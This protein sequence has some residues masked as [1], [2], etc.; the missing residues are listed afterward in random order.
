[1]PLPSPSSTSDLAPSVRVWDPFVRVLH[2]GLVA[3]VATAWWSGDDWKALHLASGYIAAAL[4]TARVVWGFV[5]PRHARF[6]EFV[7]RPVVVVRYL[8]AIARGRQARYLGHNP[9]GGAM[10]AALLATLAAVCFTGWLLT[11]DAFWGTVTMEIVHET[12]TNIALV[13]IAAHVVGVAVASIRHRENLVRSMFTGYK[14]AP[15]P[16]DVA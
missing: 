2:W 4:I 6:S 3:A 10:I 1:M 12:L 15:R 5:G 9:A 7:R 16:D 14:S 8:R 11:T 13:L